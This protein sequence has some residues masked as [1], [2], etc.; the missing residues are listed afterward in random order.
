[1]KDTK[2]EIQYQTGGSAILTVK[3]KKIEL[4]KE[5]FEH[6]GRGQHWR[7]KLGTNI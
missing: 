4:P 1:L 7:G 5:V 3:G 2:A 6:I